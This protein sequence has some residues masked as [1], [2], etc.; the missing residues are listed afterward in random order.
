MR[1]IRATGNPVLSDR[2]AQRAFDTIINPQWHIWSL[3]NDELKK[4][5]AFH[6]NLMISLPKLVSLPQL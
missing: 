3:T 2:L 1:V 5:L 4:D 6:K